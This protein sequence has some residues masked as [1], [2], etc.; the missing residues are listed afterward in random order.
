MGAINI[1]FGDAMAENF[2]AG[3]GEELEPAIE[4][5]EPQTEPLRDDMVDERLDMQR[6]ETAIDVR[7]VLETL[8]PVERQVA[9]KLKA[10]EELSAEQMAA[11]PFIKRKLAKAGLGS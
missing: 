3:K 10:G 7:S 8:S 1:A 2:A 11:V 9:E 4:T 6:V 5:R